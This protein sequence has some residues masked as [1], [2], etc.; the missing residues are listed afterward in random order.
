V[1]IPANI[2]GRFLRSLSGKLSALFGFLLEEI[3]PFQHCNHQQT[4]MGGAF[5]N[6]TPAP[7][8]VPVAQPGA[9]LANL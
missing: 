5:C 3:G 8:F 9:I 1:L 7:L 6:K 4:K 2:H